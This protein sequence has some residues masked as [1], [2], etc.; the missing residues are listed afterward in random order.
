MNSCNVYQPVAH[1][2]VLWNVIAL[3]LPVVT[4]SVPFHWNNWSYS[5]IKPVH[6]IPI[7]LM[8]VKDAK[9][10]FVSAM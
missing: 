7:A 8:V 10:L 9:T 1:L 3:P 6:V 5:I 2:I 4:V